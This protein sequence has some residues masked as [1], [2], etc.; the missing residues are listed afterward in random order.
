MRIVPPTDERAAISCGLCAAPSGVADRPE[1]G[2][3]LQAPRDLSRG[4]W[5]GRV[6]VADDFDDL[7]YDVMDAFE[8]TG[9]DEP[10]A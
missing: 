7:P 8:G 9:G 5:E 3:L 4:L 6:R 2:R 10:P 1:R